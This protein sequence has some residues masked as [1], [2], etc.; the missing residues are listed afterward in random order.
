[1]ACILEAKIDSKG[2]RLEWDPATIPATKPFVHICTTPY[3]SFTSFEDMN[4][5]KTRSSIFSSFHKDTRSVNFEIGYS[6]SSKWFE[7]LKDKWTKYTNFYV[8]GFLEAIYSSNEKNTEI[9]YAQV[10]AKII[11]FDIKSSQQNASTFSL[12]SAS[13]KSINNAFTKRRSQSL[14]N[15]PIKSSTTSKYKDPFVLSTQ[16][17]SDV[18]TNSVITIDD[19]END[20]HPEDSQMDANLVADN[21]LDDESTLQSYNS[22]SGLP[23]RT[24]SKKNLSDLC[25]DDKTDDQDDDQQE[26]PNDKRKQ[27]KK[28]KRAY[29]K[30]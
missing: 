6:K 20:D 4:F 28:Q 11:D 3:D 27:P 2:Q 15:S 1:M 13:P 14:T 21:Y 5:V 23:K 29:N 19:I 10:D 9:T 30:K 16:K 25:K 24:R 8:G 12:Q 17:P 18:S 26:E 22:I 7:S